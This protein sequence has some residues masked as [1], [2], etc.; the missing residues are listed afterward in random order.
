[1]LCEF[2]MLG[3]LLWIPVTGVTSCA[4]HPIT[5]INIT[6]DLQ[7]DVLLPCN[8]TLPVFGANETADI[9]AV[10]SHRN[11]TVDDLVEIKLQSD[12]KSCRNTGGCI[13]PFPNIS[14][15]GNFS[16]LLRNVQRSDLGLYRCELYNGTNCSIAYQEIYLS[17]VSE[18]HSSIQYWYYLLGAAVTV[19]LLLVC[20][21]CTQCRRRHSEGPLYVNTYFHKNKRH[22][23]E[24]PVYENDSEIRKLKWTSRGSSPKQEDSLY[25]NWVRNKR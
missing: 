23:K 3:M 14:R 4:S 20:L 2:G 1:M 21:F 8:F 10:W 11:L 19:L 12:V 6:T 9:A 18:V 7:S 15:S 5:S 24:E 25:V 16:I 22:R 17:T 13:N